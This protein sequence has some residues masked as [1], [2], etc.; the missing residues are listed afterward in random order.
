MAT[1]HFDVAVVGAGPAGIAAACTCARGG[2]KTIIF[3]RGEYPGSKNVM[4]GVLYRQ[5]TE[6]VV[7]DIWGRAPLERPIIEQ[8]AWLLTEDSAVSLGYRTER[9]AKQP[10]NNFTV[11]RAK[12]DRWFAQEAVAQGALLVTET[13]VDDLLH[14]DRGRVVGVHTGRDQ[15]EISANLVIL[16]EG[17]NSILAQKE[18]LQGHLK[19]E[20]LAVVAKEIIA[21]PR[22]KIEDRFNLEG[23]E[24]ATIEFIGDATLGMM[25][26]AFIYTNKDSLSV[27]CGALLSQMLRQK[28]NPNV[29]LEHFKEHPMVR[30]LL[31]G[32]D[33]REYLAHMIPEGGLSAMP[34]LFADG[35]MVVGDTA[36]MV[37]SIHREGSNM[38]M[39]SGRL[40]GETALEAHQAGNFTVTALQNY[41]N[42]LEESFIFSDLAKYRNASMF[43]EENPQFFSLY[44]KLLD[45]AAGELTLVDNLPKKDKQR[46]IMGRIFQERSA[47]QILKDLYRLWRVM[48]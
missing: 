33:S 18:G 29:L 22:E 35:I 47:W 19:T 43:F 24:G 21:L 6:D 26:T 14:D 46:K 32:G 30:R 34:R 31:Q 4:G 5:A 13:V 1:E 8:R 16:A 44:P 38:A 17:V 20:N 25:G 48:G 3:D 9:Y 2:L 23:D 12:F 15:G 45:Y 27:G 36:Q 7:P 28:V 37:N 39:T 40:A 42:K 10:Y 41:Q 11:L